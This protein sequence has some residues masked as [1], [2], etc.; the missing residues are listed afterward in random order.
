MRKV[1]NISLCK[2]LEA[3]ALGLLGAM[4]PRCLHDISTMIEERCARTWT[5]NVY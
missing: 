5:R 2:M 3:Q 1:V 4:T